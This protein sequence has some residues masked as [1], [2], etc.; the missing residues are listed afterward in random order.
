MFCIQEFKQGDFDVLWFRDDIESARKLV[1]ER[2][3]Q[4]TSEGYKYPSTALPEDVDEFEDWRIMAILAEND[5]PLTDWKTDLE[6]AT[7][8]KDIAR[9]MWATCHEETKEGTSYPF[10]TILNQRNNE[11]YAG[12]FFIGGHYDKKQTGNLYQFLSI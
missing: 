3:A 4:R 6:L 11:W 1:N 2:I 8:F 5:H 7:K 9:W 12:P 10:W